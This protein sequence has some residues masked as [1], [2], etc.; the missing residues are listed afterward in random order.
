MASGLTPASQ[1]SD[2]QAVPPHPTSTPIPISG[3]HSGLQ[4]W[5]EEEEVPLKFLNPTAASASESDANA[6]CA[7]AASVGM[8]ALPPLQLLVY[9]RLLEL[10]MQSPAPGSTPLKEVCAVKAGPPLCITKTGG[11]WIL[12][13]EPGDKHE[14][15]RAPPV[16]RQAAALR[17][18]LSSMPARAAPLHALPGMMGD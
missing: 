17:R 8:R 5:E 9:S 16:T 14:G 3:N 2:A 4:R 10:G 6:V 7:T 12:A 18:V 15:A 11:F 13:L 1:A